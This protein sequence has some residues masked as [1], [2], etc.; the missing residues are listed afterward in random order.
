[1][2]DVGGKTLGPTR[3]ATVHSLSADGPAQQNH[4]PNVP[5]EHGVSF[6][7][8]G[9]DQSSDPRVIRVRPHL[10]IAVLCIASAPSL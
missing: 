10:S 8:A 3:Y 7:Y 2:R 4:Q 5:A 9:A 1:M 6:S